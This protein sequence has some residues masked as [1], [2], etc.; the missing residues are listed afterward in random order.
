MAKIFITIPRYIMYD[1][2]SLPV[3]KTIAFGGVAM[4][5]MKAQLAPNTRGKLKVAMG[6]SI[7]A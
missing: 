1:M 7:T 6:I 4:G 5:S 3:L 2:V